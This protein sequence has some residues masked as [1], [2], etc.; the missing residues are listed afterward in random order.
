[1]IS[2]KK[3]IKEAEIDIPISKEHK[4][5]LNLADTQLVEFVEHF[6][7]EIE[8]LDMTI[9]SKNYYKAEMSR[10]LDLISVKRTYNNI[11]ELNDNFN[12]YLNEYKTIFGKSYEP[13]KM[14]EEKV[15]LKASI[16]NLKE[17][18]DLLTQLKETLDKINNFELKLIIEEPKTEKE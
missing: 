13:I 9:N 10:L 3:L 16:F 4:L 11:E 15:L 6:V 14:N 2:V 1:M 18:E 8:K 5:M 17:Y 12:F 7:S